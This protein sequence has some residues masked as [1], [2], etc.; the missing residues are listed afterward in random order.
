MNV[1]GCIVVLFQACDAFAIFY[2]LNKKHQS[3]RNW[4]IGNSSSLLLYVKLPQLAYYRTIRV[5]YIF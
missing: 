2:C 3:D 5:Q 1:I 4:R